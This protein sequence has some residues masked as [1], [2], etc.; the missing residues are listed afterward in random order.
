MRTGRGA[1]SGR[2]VAPRPAASVVLLRRGGEH[3]DRAL[4]VLLLKR[5]DAAI[6]AQCLGV[7]RRRSRSRGRRRTRPVVGPALCGSWPRRPG[8]SCRRPR[9]SSSFRAG[10]LQSWSRAASMPGSSSPSPQP[11]RHRSPTA[12]RRPRQPG[13][14]RGR[15][16]RPTPRGELTLAFPT[17]KQLESLLHFGSAEEAL[18]AHR[19]RDVEPIL[20]RLIGSQRGSPRRPSR[21]SRLPDGAQLSRGRAPARRARGRA[22]RCECRSLP[23]P[24]AGAR[25]VGRHFSAPS[26]APP[27][28]ARPVAR[29]T[30]AGD[31]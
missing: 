17:V 20:P 28:C 24:P 11:T 8:S 27:R 23:S 25:T 9:S 26:S 18:D 19:D 1:Q 15:R 4:E 30:R 12:S 2:A 10:S 13:L 29:G 16:S 3:S 14:S 6:H 31:R 22:G 7:S 21:R 5:A